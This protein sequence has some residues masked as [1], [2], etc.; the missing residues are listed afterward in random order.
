MAAAGY[1]AAVVGS[2]ARCF[3][4]V[5]LPGASAPPLAM[6]SAPPVFIGS[7]EVEKYLHRASL[8]LPALEAAL[9]N[10][11]AGAAGGVVQPV[12]AVVPVRPHGG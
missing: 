10:F 11:S 1:L 2:R 8:L 9:G 6:S 3:S 4:P 5:S 12:R 7:E